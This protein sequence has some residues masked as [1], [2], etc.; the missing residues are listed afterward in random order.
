M[1]IGGCGRDG[2]LYIGDRSLHSFGAA[3]AEPAGWTSMHA[4]AKEMAWHVSCKFNQRGRKH[5]TKTNKKK[6][7]CRYGAGSIDVD[8]GPEA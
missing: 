4:S 6:F 5:R 8:K 7:R 2:H 3:H 1:R